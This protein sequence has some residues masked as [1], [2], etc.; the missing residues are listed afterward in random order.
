VSA[1]ATAPDPRLRTHSNIAAWD[2]QG[3]IAQALRAEGK[4]DTE[5]A[6]LLGVTPR[7][8]KTR[9]ARVASPEEV[10]YV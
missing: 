3:F 9:R 2:Q 6:R 4:N 8:V 5:I 7:T 1:G 10:P